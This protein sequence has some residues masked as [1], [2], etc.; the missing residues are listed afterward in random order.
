MLSRMALSTCFESPKVFTIDRDGRSFHHILNVL[1]EGLEAYS[2]VLKTLSDQELASL[3]READFYA[4]V[5]LSKLIAKGQTTPQW[6]YK[7]LMQ[8]LI[9]K[10][11]GIGLDETDE[12]PFNEQLKEHVQKGWI[13]DG[14]FRISTIRK[15]Y[16]YLFQRIKRRL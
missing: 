15:S 6:E 11:F 7:V 14:D 16:A 10:R 12:Q 3:S 9:Y 1:R 2:P 13:P 4:L 8:T 5:D